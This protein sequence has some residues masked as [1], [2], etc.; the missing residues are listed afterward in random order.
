MNRLQKHWHAALGVLLW[1]P[2]SAGAH[3]GD[4]LYPVSWLSEEMLA[5]VRMDGRIDEW[6]ELIGEPAMT[7][8]DFRDIIKEVPADPASLDFRIW[9]A[10]HDDPARFYLTFVATDDV[11]E[12]THDYGVGSPSMSFFDSIELAIDGDHSGGVGC[13]YRFR[14]C[15]EVEDA[16]AEERGQTQFYSAIARTPD[17]P[18]LDDGATRF[19][20]ESSPGRYFPL[21]EKGPE[22]WLEKRRLSASSSCMLPRST[23]GRMGMTAP[24]TTW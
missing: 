17:G 20:T 11:Y 3:V 2:A 18:I 15:G 7:T 19:N 22:A 13:N 12:N 8:L 16:W 14:D 6:F 23:G 9:L 10:W 5:E 4:R 21:S 24:E 1:V